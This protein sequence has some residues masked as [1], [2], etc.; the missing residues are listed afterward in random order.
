MNLS[1]VGDIGGKLDDDDRDNEGKYIAFPG[2]FFLF[3]L[4]NLSI[5][6]NK[7]I[8]VSKESMSVSVC[9]ENKPITL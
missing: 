1:F 9:P 4:F 5:E 7:S 3:E 6:F 2:E 8:S